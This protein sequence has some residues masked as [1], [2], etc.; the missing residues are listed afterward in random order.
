MF[1]SYTLQYLNLVNEV[2]G[3]LNSKAR[4]WPLYGNCSTVFHGPH[5]KACKY[6]FTF[7]SNGAAKL[8][9]GKNT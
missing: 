8:H 4:H 2:N 5:N 7:S 9:K 1:N 3:I 6:T